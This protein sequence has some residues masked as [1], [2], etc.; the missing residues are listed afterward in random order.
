MRVCVPVNEKGM[1]GKIQMKK[2]WR[3]RPPLKKTKN[4]TRIFVQ[5][6]RTAIVTGA[7]I[8]SEYLYKLVWMV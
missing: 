5:G 3:I 2:K 7:R 6:N 8:L 1:Q 4:V